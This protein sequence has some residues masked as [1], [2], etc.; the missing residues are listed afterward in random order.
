MF[1]MNADYQAGNSI[2]RVLKLTMY[3]S[4]IV[5]TFNPIK[6][7]NSTSITLF[8]RSYNVLKNWYAIKTYTKEN[9]LSCPSGPLCVGLE[10]DA[11]FQ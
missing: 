4:Y 7:G 1:S 2:K 6:T 11:A 9:V 8:V 10:I 5:R 3:S